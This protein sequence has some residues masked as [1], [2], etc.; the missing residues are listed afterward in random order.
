MAQLLSF[1]D[2]GIYCDAGKFYI[3]PYTGVDRAVITHAHSDH[4]KWGSRY[5]LAHKNSIPLLKLRLGHDIAAQS[6]DYNE[7]L[8][9][10]GVKVSFH[11]AGHV[12]GSAQIRVEY[13]GEVWV[14]S[15]DYKTEDD[16]ISAAFEPVNCHTFITESTFGLPVYRWK[17]QAEVFSQ[18]NNW[19]RKNQQM[20]RTSI[21]F[22]YSL[23]KAQ[24][25]LQYLDKSI[26]N[27]YAHTA[28]YNVQQALY[29]HGLP[30]Y[31]VKRYN[32]DTPKNTSDI[33]VAPSMAANS[34]WLKRFE[35]Y[36]TGFC[37]G[38]MQVRGLQR[39]GNADAGFVLS[40]H[41]DWNGLLTAIRATG[42]QKVFVTHGYQSVF[43]RYLTETGIEAKEV[44]TQYGEEEAEIPEV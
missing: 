30:V 34:P 7:V 17:K 27:I 42:A 8:D 33:I 39:R 2:K 40:N 25:I 38:W 9:L 22:G 16:G 24:R 41:A 13:K 10:N 29:S 5:Y 35:P 14:A 32:Y 3:D 23:G 19:W 31:N 1:T 4:T 12:I 36:T 21:I 37:S 6:V 11:P 18:I 28:V 44:V 20:R 26:G 43:A 15:G